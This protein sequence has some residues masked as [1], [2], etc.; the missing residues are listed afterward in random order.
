MTVPVR[1]D[2]TFA[3]A[4]WGR[5]VATCPRPYCTNALA[6]YPRQ[7]LF[8]CMAEDGCG[9]VADVVWPTDPD[10]IQ[11]VLMMRPVA[12]TRNWKPGETI[13]D[14]LMENAAHGC[15]PSTSYADLTTA[16][17][18]VTVTTGV[19]ALVCFGSWMTNDTGGAR[20][21]MSYTMSGATSAAAQDLTSSSVQITTSSSGCYI[22]ATRTYMHTSLTSGSTTFKTQYKV[23]TG[24]GT[25]QQ[26]TLSV[27]PL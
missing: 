20:A 25:Y 11:T 14:L 27:L 12:A 5:W 9:Y 15:L 13:D 17:P 16:G 26:R 3:E 7:T 2:V 18:Q 8:V 19:A 21:L 6:L 22:A 23:S 24:T 4:N 10:A 1:D